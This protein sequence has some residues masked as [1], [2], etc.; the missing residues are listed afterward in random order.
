MFPEFRKNNP[1][2]VLTESLKGYF[3]LGNMYSPYALWVHH[4]PIEETDG[5][6]HTVLMI[7]LAC[8]LEYLYSLVLIQVGVSCRVLEPNRLVQRLKQAKHVILRVMGMYINGV[9]TKICNDDVELVCVLWPHQFLYMLKII[10]ILNSF[11]IEVDGK[12]KVEWDR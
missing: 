11:K 9:I 12:G 1:D 8:P 10:M 7:Q 4:P 5:L 6:G 2:P 3:S